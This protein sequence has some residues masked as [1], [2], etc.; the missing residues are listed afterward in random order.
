[1]PRLSSVAAGFSLVMFS[2]ACASSG[3]SSA[4][5]AGGGACELQ[6]KDSV[7]AMYAPVYRDC[8]V[9]KKARLL[10]PELHPDF[11]PTRE[12]CYSADFEYLVDALG[13]VNP[14]TIQKL[15][16]TDQTLADAAVAILPLR[17][18]EPAVRDSVAVAQIV[19]DRFELMMKRI[20]VPA[21]T[22]PNPGRAGPGC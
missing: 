9:Q 4:S 2:L 14:S 3:A 5:T 22:R 15:K 17:R 12:G 19:T 18:Y 21:G 7:Y 13:R 8:A 20:V 6:P 1:M 10:N 16:A 11:K